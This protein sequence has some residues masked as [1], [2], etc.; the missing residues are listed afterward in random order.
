MPRVAKLG[1]VT[2][3]VNSDEHLPPHVHVRGGEKKALLLIATGEIHKG[4]LSPPDFQKARAY[5]LENTAAL[6]AEWKRLN[7]SLR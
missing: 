6:M 2:V 4:E 7:P 3:S 1:S 5:V